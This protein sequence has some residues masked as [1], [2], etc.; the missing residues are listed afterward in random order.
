MF[1]ALVTDIIIHSENRGVSAYCAGG[2]GPGDGVVVVLAWTTVHRH[3]RP[4]TIS[5]GTIA[6]EFRHFGRRRNIILL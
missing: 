1:A 4:V 5:R 3:S 2:E 6:R